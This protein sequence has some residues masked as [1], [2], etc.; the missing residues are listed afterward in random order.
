MVPGL[1]L[2]KVYCLD[3]SMSC[4]AT[5]HDLMPFSLFGFDYISRVSIRNVYIVYFRLPLQ[6]ANEGLRLIPEDV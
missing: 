2:I 6:M 1:A 4:A 5:C 3:S